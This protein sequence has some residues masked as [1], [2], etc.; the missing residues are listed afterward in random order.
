MS[1]SHLRLVAAGL[2][3]IVAVLA[4][5]F[6]GFTGASEVCTRSTAQP[7]T[8][9]QGAPT[10]SPGGQDDGVS[11]G[12]R[13]DSGQQAPPQ[14]AA[15]ER[16][17]KSFSATSALAGFTGAL[18]AA[19]VVGGVAL[20][21]PRRQ[22]FTPEPPRPVSTPPVAVADPQVAKDRATLVE[23]CIYVRDRATSKAIADRLG[24]ALQQVGV[25]EVAPTGVAFDPAHHEAGGA[26]ATDD[27]RHAGTVAAVEIPGYTDRG[28]VL[29]AP[30]VTVYRGEPR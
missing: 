22:A 23:T 11:Q 15:G 1:T 2:S 9:G 5:V 20:F 8:A 13:T 16:C 21:V 7:P 30:V 3:L 19:L 29:R 4:G 12:G 25:A 18:L 17:E 28:A 14:T 27:P 24:W 10:A 26:V 6:T